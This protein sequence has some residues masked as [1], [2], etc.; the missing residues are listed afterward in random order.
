MDAFVPHEVEWT[1]EKVGRFWDYLAKN[2]SKEDAYFSHVLGRLVVRY[3]EKII[4]LSEPILDFGCGPGFLMAIL[5]ERGYSVRGMDFSVESVQK[6]NERCASHQQYGGSVLAQEYPS[7]ITSDSIGTVFL[8]EALEHLLPENIPRVLG[9]I[10]RMLQ[11]G[12]S[13][14]ITTPNQEDLRAGQIMCPDCGCVFHSIQ[15]VVSWSKQGLTDLLTSHGFATV[16][17]AETVFRK[18]DGSNVLYK[19]YYAFTGRR[20]PNLIYVGRKL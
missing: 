4:R 6:A 7:P 12:G 3:A 9:E 17:C 20:K 18:G 19:L 10:H 2:T 8:V 11:Q 16:G 15:H 13:L 14:V 1:S 5:L